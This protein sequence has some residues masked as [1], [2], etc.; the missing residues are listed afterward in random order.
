[1]QSIR[2]RIT[3]WGTIYYA[4]HNNAMAMKMYKKAIKLDSKS[5]SAYKNL[6]AAYFNKGKLR[7]GA[8][9]FEQALILDPNVLDRQGLSMQAE[10]RGTLVTM[11][12]FLAQLCA[13]SGRNDA[14]IAYLNR[15]IANGFRDYGR[16]QKDDAFASVREMPEFPT[17]GARR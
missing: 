17:P 16:L 10:D 2:M 14:A 12:Y 1:M 7:Q 5:S 8:E 11:N 6:G 3:T 4:R 13:K 9:A 15:A